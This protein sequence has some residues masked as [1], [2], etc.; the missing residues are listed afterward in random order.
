MFGCRVRACGHSLL[1]AHKHWTHMCMRDQQNDG[2]VCMWKL[3]SGGDAKVGYMLALGIGRRAPVT[4]NLTIV[5]P[6]TQD[7]ILGAHKGPVHCLRF[8]GGFGPKGLLFTGSVDHTLKVWDPFVRDTNLKVGAE[9]HTKGYTGSSTH[10]P[11]PFS[12]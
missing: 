5:C 12:R 11:P 6:T 9:C 10:Q 2:V 8:D 7:S 1:R 4:Y 3:G